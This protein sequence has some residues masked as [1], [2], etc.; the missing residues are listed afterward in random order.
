[1][2]LLS[3]KSNL[4]QTS[5]GKDEQI[6]DIQMF[7]DP[8]LLQI[9]AHEK[10]QMILTLLIK[11]EMTIIDLKNETNLNPG[12]IKRH[13]TQLIEKDL[14][15]QSRTEINKYGIKMKFYRAIA[16]QFEINIKYRWP[17]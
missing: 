1:M 5:S 4:N 17:E 6:M 11:K 12:T 10:N 14:I 13:L 15:K 16:K 9:L 7:T 2:I 8:D 3:K